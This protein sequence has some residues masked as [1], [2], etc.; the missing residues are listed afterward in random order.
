MTRAH[1]HVG[2][3]N[4]SEEEIMKAKYKLAL[5]SFGLGLLVTGCPAFAD[6]SGLPNQASVKT[7]V[8]A[9]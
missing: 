1:P 4:Y 2:I 3:H 8:D 9:T 7:A 5:G 6:C